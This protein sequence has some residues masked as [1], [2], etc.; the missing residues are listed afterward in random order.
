M[1]DI[2]AKIGDEMGTNP[3]VGPWVYGN[4]NR[5]GEK[6]IKFV[7]KCNFKIKG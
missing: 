3:V 1:G 5:N 7:N 4:T 2:N 6:I